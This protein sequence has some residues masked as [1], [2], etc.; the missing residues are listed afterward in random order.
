MHSKLLLAALL[1][2]PFL[3]GCEDSGPAISGTITMAPE[4]QKTLGTSDT[5]FVV[6][7]PKQAGGP[8]LAV[9]RI[10]GAKFPLDYK[11]TQEDV[12]MPNTPFQGEVVVEAMIRKSGT[13][14]MAVP[15]DMEGAFDRPVPIGTSDV[16][17]AIDKVQK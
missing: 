5:L 14:G 2:A 11:I 10:V 7:K 4:L 17:I 6:A 16:D 12:M 1:V 8:P 15:G 3:G 13:V 9:L